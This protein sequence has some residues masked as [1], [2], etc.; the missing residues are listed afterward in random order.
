MTARHDRKPAAGSAVYGRA[1]LVALL[2]AAVVSHAQSDAV[3]GAQGKTPEQWLDGMHAAFDE[4]GYDGVFIYRG[5]SNSA[6]LRIVHLNVDGVKRIRLVHLNGA[7]R[8]VIRR[9]DQV[10][11]MVT[12]NDETM[13]LG[14]G[15]PVGPWGRSFAPRFRAAEKHYRIRIDGE[16]RIAG[17]RAVH[18]MLSPSD[19]NRFGHRLWL[20]RATGLLLRSELHD[21]RGDNLEE[22]QFASLVVG[23]GIPESALDPEPGEGWVHEPLT[24]ERRDP[25]TEPAPISWHAGW[26]PDGFSMADAEVRELGGVGA[27]VTT[28]MWS[29]GLAAFHVFV[30]ATP[31]RRAG[32]LV[33]RD[34]AT[35]VVTHVVTPPRMERHLVTV[36]GEVPTPTAR[37]IAR[38]VYHQ[39]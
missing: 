22:F 20:D 4:L 19:E 13:R 15:D 35:V 27:A 36:V 28:M 25:A 1:M 37:R 3:Q 34:G 26:V 32:D 14:H 38:S 39:D 24:A 23:E 30:E 9:G 6:M 16:D 18:I 29:D 21:A 10:V 11:R 7:P 2:A 17:R 5:G 12:S 33:S 31:D 8:E